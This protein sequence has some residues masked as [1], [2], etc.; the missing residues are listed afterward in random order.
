MR[1]T[2]TAMIMCAVMV[3]VALVP[4]VSGGEY[5]I[6][7]GP[8]GP[9]ASAMTWTYEPADYGVW[10]AKLDNHGLRSMVLDVYD[11]T[12]GALEQRLHQRIRFAAYDAYP[13]G[14]VV[15]EPVSMARGHTYEITATP[16]GPRQSYAVVSDQFMANLSPI[17]AFNYTTD[18]L[19]VNVD[20]SASYDPDG[21]IT[22]YVWEW[23]DGATGSGV[24]ASHTYMMAD[25]YMVTLTVV[26]D[27]GS[28]G[29][30]THEVTVMEPPNVPPIASFT[31]SK[32]YLDVSVD[33]SASYDTD[34][35][36]VGYVWNWGDGSPDDMSASP[37]A[38]H[39]Y[40]MGGT[41]TITLTVTDNDG[42]TGTAM[43]DVTVEPY[44]DMP[45][46]AMFSYST[47]YLD[48]SF[49]ASLSSDDLGIV[50]Y[51]WDFG[52]GMAGSGVMVTHEYAMSGT[53]TVILTVTDTI[54]Q[55]DSAMADVTVKANEPPVAMFTTTINWLK[56]MVDAST[57]HDPEGAIASYA[58]DFGDGTL[59]SGVT[60]SHTYS[61]DGTYTITLTVADAMGLTDSAAQDWTVSHEPLPPVAMFTVVTNFLE[62]SVDGS[63]SYDPDGTV[64]SYAWAFGDGATAMGATASHTYAMDDTYLVTLT[65][66][67][68]E[69]LTGSLTKSVTVSHEMIA[70]VAWF[71]IATNWLQVSVAA[72]GSY[73]LDG[74]IVS[75]A[76]AF[77][78]GG[79]AMGFTA[80]HTYAMDGTYTITLTT[81]DNDGLTTSLSRPVTVMHEPIPP[82]A[83]FTVI[84]NYLQVSVD[85]SASAD[86]DGPIAQYAWDFGDGGNAMGV[87]A[88]HTYLMDGTYTITLTV[89]DTDG[90]TDSLSKSVTVAHQ[91][92]P[93]VAAFTVSATYLTVQVDASSSVDPDGTITSYAWDFGDGATAMGVMASHE[94]TID[95]TYLIVLV[96]TDNEGLTGSAEKWVTVSAE[97]VP[98]VAVMSATTSW[99][100]VNVDGS[101]S[102]DT[103][104]SIVSWAWTFGDGATAM[105]A[106]A[107]HTYAMDGTYTVTLTVTDNDGLTDSD[108]MS[109]TV[110]HEPMPPTA[111]FSSSTTYLVVSVD[112]STSSDPDGTITSYAWA[113][114][115]GAT[116]TGV[117]ATHEYATDGTYLITL[118]V[119]DNDM[120]T[121]SDSK[122]VTVSHALVS[123]VAQFTTLT[124]WLQVSV[125][126]SGSYDPDGTIVSYAWDFGDGGSAMGVTATHTYSGDGTYSITLTVTDNDGLTATLSKPVT[127]VHEPIPP[128]AAFSVLTTY[129][130][131]NVDA[132]GSSDA[133]GMIA[134][135]AWDFGDGGTAT[136]V[137]AMHAYAVDGTYTITLTVTDNDGLTDTEIKSVT[138]AHQLIPPN[139]AFT[140]SA[141]WEVASFDGSGSSDL[142]GLITA[143][144]WNFGDG[145]TGSGM[146]AT[147]TY[148][149]SGS[150]SVT[151]TVTDNEA[152]T[153]SI[154]KTVTVTYNNPPVASFSVTKDYLEV[155]VDAS[156][157]TDD[158]GIASY[159]WSYGDGGSGS[160]VMDSHAYAAAGTYTVSL[161]VVDTGG[162]SA[163]TS[164]SV[165]VVQNPPPT[166]AISLVSTNFLM[167]TLSGAG[168]TDDSAIVSYAWNFGDGSTGS[169]VSVTHTYLVDGTY[170]LTLTVTD[171]R[172]LTG[173]DTLSVTVAAQDLPP[174]AAF[175][176][177]VTDLTVSVDASSS[178]D[179]HGIVSYAW[180]CGDGT[181]GFDVTATHTY[182][183]AMALSRASKF[184]IS[185]DARAILPPYYVAGT[186]YMSGGGALPG[187]SLT[188]TN[189][190]TGE[191]MVSTSD[192]TGFYMAEIA[193]GLPSAYLLG[194]TIRVDA[195]KGTASGSSQGVVVAGGY[196]QVDVY[197][198]DSGPVPIL[199]TITLTVTDAK[200][201]T[202][203]V[204]H[205][206][207]L[208]APNVAPV[209]SFTAT[210]TYLV[211]QV[212]GLASSDAD[213]TIASY[214]WT[215]G[216]GGTATGVTASHTYAADGT[217]TITLTVTDNDGATGTTSKSVTVT[218]QLKPPTA[219]FSWSAI[220]EVASFDGSASSDSDGT[221]TAWNW[222][223]GDTTT[224]SGK[225]VTHS[226]VASGAYSVRLTVTDNEGLTGSITKTVTVLY[227]SLPVAAFTVTK[228]FLQILVDAST[229]TDDIGIASYSWS[230]G[231]GGSGSGV[232]DSHTYAA[233][234]TY[235]VS[236]T[237]V[238]TGGKS[239]TTSKS[240]SVVQNTPPTAVISVVSIVDLT[241]TLSGEGSID[242]TAIASYDWS[243]GDGQTGS[244]VQVTHA[245]AAGGTYTVSL[246]ITDDHGLSGSATLDIAVTEPI[247]VPEKT[248][249]LYD[250][251]QEPWGWWWPLRWQYYSTDVIV[252]DEPG[253]S[254][255]YFMPGKSAASPYSGLFYAPYRFSVDARNQTTLSLSKPEFMPAFGPAVAG[256]EAKIDVYSQYLEPNWWN[257]YW[258]PTWSSEPLWKGNDWIYRSGADGYD[259]GTHYTVNMN[260]Q[261]AEQWLNLPQ[262]AAD[263]LTWWAAN[264]DAYITN[265]VAWINFEGNKRLDIYC[266]YEWPYD[267]NGGTFMTLKEEADGSLTLDIGH[268]ALGWEIL[269]TRWFVETKICP[270]EVYMEDI[271]LSAVYKANKVDVMADFVAQ[272]SMHAVKQNKTAL[273]DTASAWAWEGIKIDY[274]TRIGH[275]SQYKWYSSIGYQSWNC[276]DPAFGTKV[277]YEA[278]PGWFNLTDGD[279]LIL[280]APTGTVPG[281]KAVALLDE[282]IISAALGDKTAV[283]AIMQ[284]GTMDLGYFRTAPNEVGQPDL[285]PGWSAATKTLTIVGPQNF[286]NHRHKSGTTTPAPTPVPAGGNPLYHGAPWIE[287]NV[288][289]PAASAS[290]PGAEVTLRGEVVGPASA[291]A[292]SVT[293]LAALS[294][295]SAIVL[296]VVIRNRKAE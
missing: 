264:K 202:N 233:A 109:V 289:Q 220:W 95:G 239:S 270:L 69:G 188:L 263:P 70:P 171:D 78:D 187:C 152:L 28:T 125:D 169:G 226:Y 34:G 175:T 84:A 282:D 9:R 91:L 105:G 53:Y 43:Q 119:T 269:L 286:D 221:I 62:I 122:S 6:V 61:M 231:D 280:K 92:I 154:T 94:Y 277:P 296:L 275:P 81:M 295:A 50:S 44:V 211:V 283:Y 238:D 15:S 245:Y 115:D 149:A 40:A 90:L 52:D 209:A 126:A 41:Y 184:G 86:P 164:K 33:A 200:G 102:Y 201:Q 143:W 72:T 190:R 236:L 55:T 186:T 161:T 167:V 87:T 156:A 129:L 247:P 111:A 99:L 208:T 224:G 2:A 252:T 77:G 177:S 5:I 218:H 276:G 165:S 59:A 66:T 159:A 258:V 113:F 63:G 237:V 157:S 49:D 13:A 182:T 170:T 68:N 254:T 261:A 4:L 79:T 64:V 212:D 179:D 107:S 133:D 67:D 246:T 260:R 243:F 222:V 39:S 60:A 57:S 215:F 240:V 256:A 131:V 45:P 142:D 173:T 153:G 288:V 11:N 158:F 206:V 291:I 75:Y 155:F 146:T 22:D 191:S 12:S 290:M 42:D 183:L 46:V 281:F 144:A 118:T 3:L 103:D 35:T 199:R 141:I 229:S 110:V 172:G 29:S 123:P 21:Y 257:S 196:I 284:N 30:I 253:M 127:V 227:N 120:L 80:S 65:V 228:D 267:I 287:F 180:A 232:M 106:I 10:N 262:T 108:S 148:T 207:E 98:P 71:D 104:G 134:S 130:V 82:T 266:G 205:E 189:L 147:H 181:T 193:N 1:R 73:D 17:A 138:V 101:A 249:L 114:G 36:V 136:G 137:T 18:Y 23:G 150:Y 294:L 56:V 244:G 168:S 124:T 58:W 274:I 234:G 74:T 268:I 216:D 151:L 248:Y 192:A 54:G 195:V 88:V 117:T 292:D 100:T 163:T 250:M 194:D 25:T 166:A 251:F 116:A 241:A 242:E 32:L 174:T 235:T 19:S 279:K 204:S 225:T 230:Y 16:N 203:S 93:P 214:A 176:Y 89:T 47:N 198:I 197:L 178:S 219:A 132:S 27:L 278:T 162:K 272:Y 223:F 7:K 140:W 285:R 273:G 97:P 293:A 185:V 265:W 213:G 14:V 48:T 145:M 8:Q 83:A 26:D 37:V 38:T 121:D 255:M 85:A 210:P 24:M 20:A 76:W 259:L 217:Y 112:A 160:G 271:T 51:D 96:V 135:Y 128:L 31:V 139:A